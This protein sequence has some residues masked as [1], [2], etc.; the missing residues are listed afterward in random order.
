[1]TDF[2]WEKNADSAAKAKLLLHNRKRFAYLFA[3]VA[4][5]SI[6]AYLMITG[7][8]TGSYYITVDEL[9]ADATYVGKDIRVAG[10]VD[11]DTIRFDPETQVLSFTVAAI[12]KDNDA[13]REAGGLGNVLHNALQDPNAVRMNVEWQNAEMPDLLQHEAQAIM[14][15][16]L[17]E[18]NVFHANQVLLKCPT[19]YS[20]DVPEQAASTQ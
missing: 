8:A 11:G 2:T 14:E 20:D 15:G 5:I 16:Q 12:P 4:L 18:N 1:M 6:V 10:A 3:G 17:D 7:M 9:M 13:I 19:R